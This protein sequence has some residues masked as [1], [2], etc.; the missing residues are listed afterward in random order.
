MTL[1]EILHDLDTTHADIIRSEL[2]ARDHEIDKLHRLLSQAQNNLYGR[3]SEK[4]PTDNKQTVLFTFARPPEQAPLA[5]TSIEV[6]AHT[7]RTSKPRKELPQDLERERIEYDLDHTQCSCCGAEMAVIGEEKT[8][9]L[10]FIPARLKVIEHV[11]LK[12]ACASC[13]QGVF[14]PK[15][16][17]NVQ[18]LERAQPGPGLLAYIMVAKFQDHLPLRRQEQIFARHGVDL[19]RQRMC[20]WIGG[21]VALLTPLYRAVLQRILARTYFQADETTLKVQDGTPNKLHTGYL[22]AM[23]APP[24]EDKETLLPEAV[25][26]HYAEGR[27]AEVPRELF[28]DSHATIQTDAYAGYNPVFVPNHCVRLACMAHIRRK[29]IEAQGAAKTACNEVLKLI[30]SLYKVE[31]P[32]KTVTPD[33]R[34]RV[35]LKKAFPVLVLLYRLLRRLR[36]QTLPQA[37]FSKALEYAWGQ[38]SAMLRY[39]RDGRFEIDNNAMERQMRPIAVGRK[40]YLFAGSHDGARNAAILY[41]LINT[42]RLNKVN[43]FEYLKDVLVRI[44]EPGSLQDLLPYNWKPR[45]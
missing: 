16:P 22:W 39:L 36:K 27:A 41:T 38:K 21:S 6:A 15:L 14:T 18:P 35:R 12:R 45:T 20:D 30:A 42:C 5:P 17:Q 40:N 31:S 4:L 1:D 32:L 37:D 34:R 3:K 8:E 9:Q 2:A 28:K 11:R 26:Y 29:F 7:R 43:P 24:E 23:R 44:H 13:K 25:A 33:E 10:E 19:P